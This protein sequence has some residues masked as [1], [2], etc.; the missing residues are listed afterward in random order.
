[1]IVSH[2]S[3][4]SMDGP[5]ANA[6]IYEPLKGAPKTHPIRLCRLAPAASPDEKIRCEL[7]NTTLDA[8]EDFEALS[9]TWG[10]PKDTFRIILN[11]RPFYV[12]RNLA[13]ALLNLRHVDQKRVMWIDAICI[14]QLD[15]SEKNQQIPQ[16]KNIYCHGGAR[17][18]VVWLGTIPHARKA[19]DFC[20][21]MDF[22]SERILSWTKKCVKRRELRME[23]GSKSMLEQPY[24]DEAAE[25]AGRKLWTYMEVKSHSQNPLK[26][27]LG[28][29]MLYRGGAEWD[30]S[31]LAKV[32]GR[33]NAKFA[34][35]YLIESSNAKRTAYE[36]ARLLW[37][38]M[39]ELS[40]SQDHDPLQWQ[41]QLNGTFENIFSLFMAQNPNTT[42]SDF[43]EH[44]DAAVQESNPG[45][46]LWDRILRNKDAR[47]AARLLWEQIEEQTEQKVARGLK[48][49]QELEYKDE[50]KACRH[51]FV[52][53]LW[54][55]RMWIL[56]EVIHSGEVIVL[57][58]PGDYI[59]LEELLNANS[60]WRERQLLH[61]NDSALTNARALEDPSYTFQPIGM[62]EQRWYN[63]TFATS[64]QVTD[65][66][67]HLVKLRAAAKAAPI[68][69]HT[70]YPP[71]FGGLV[72]D[73]R[74]Q[75]AADPRDKLYA[76]QGMAAPGSAGVD[77]AVDYGVSI[78]KLYTVAARVFLKKTLNILLLVE[79][80]GRPITVDGDFPSW[81]PDYQTTQNS[82]PRYQLGMQARFSAD[83][84]IPPME[85]EPRVQQALDAETLILRG[86]YVGVVMDTFDARLTDQAASASQDAVRLIT[87][88]RDPAARYK[89]ADEL[90]GTCDRSAWDRPDPVKDSSWGPV[91]AEVGDF[92]IIVVGLKMPIVVRRVQH[93]SASRCGEK[94]KEKYLFVGGCWLVDSRVNAKIFQTTDWTHD[95]GFSPIMF[96]SASR[97][98]PSDWKAEEFTLC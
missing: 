84:G 76:L 92:I 46:D 87:Y 74:D 79:S 66:R 77:I 34:E 95:S 5:D 27:F 45:N 48:R 26:Y 41:Q 58:G 13:V 54:W 30:K 42:A 1:V 69:T 24:D 90:A 50:E 61:K 20:A 71:D 64:R 38:Q 98:L 4:E 43:L 18:V 3:S 88:D 16:M 31:M 14:N 83:E 85:E 96:G 82:F 49:E 7:F 89:K 63:T 35:A 59:S 33:E 68:P 81:V 2:V 62:T 21:R 28:Q 73:F 67:S 65:P 23:Y 93:E 56:Q 97:G 37:T 52:D 44:H 70:V 32:R 8:K 15:I 75:N 78:R 72:V 11:D 40:R 10:D 22:C 29:A 36:A 25:Y 9:Y 12:T 80:S 19:I 6:Y 17:R 53:A 94:E 47:Q 55:S 51:M 39:R 60:Q 91:H 86:L 57:L